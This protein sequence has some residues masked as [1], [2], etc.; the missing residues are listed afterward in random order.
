MPLIDQL[1]LIPRRRLDDLRGWF[2]KVI[3][4]HEPGLPPRTG[5]VY[6]TSALP[7]E[8]RG[9]HYHPSCAEWFTV[10]T[11][12][13]TLFVED[14]ASG[15]RAKFALDA[16]EPVTVHVPAGLAH[17]F[18]NAPDAGQ[19]FVL[20]AYAAELYDPADTVPFAVTRE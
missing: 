8:A 3:D 13:A 9:D 1:R 17:V 12:R 18:V 2:L 15:A 5:E 7:G 10:V 16:A 11:G 19:P 6:L 20:V 4:G 14:P